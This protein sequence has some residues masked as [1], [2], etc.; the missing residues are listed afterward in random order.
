MKSRRLIARVHPV[1]RAT[2]LVILLCLAH[3]THSDRRCCQRTRNCKIPSDCTCAT[4]ELVCRY[5]V[6]N[7]LQLGKRSTQTSSKLEE[8]VISYIVRRLYW[9]DFENLDYG[10][11]FAEP[12]SSVNFVLKNDASGDES[13]DLIQDYTFFMDNIPLFP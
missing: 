1:L 8:N 3:L 10:S 6:R 2:I 4:K 5:K 12:S 9:N 11:D 13:Y 7:A